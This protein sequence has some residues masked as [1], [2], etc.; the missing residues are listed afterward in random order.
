M[1]STLGKALAGTLFYWLLAALLFALQAVYTFRSMS[2]IRYE[3]LMESVY[4]VYLFQHRIVYDG[5]STNIGWYGLLLCVYNTF[6]FG[7]NTAKFVRLAIQLVSILCL[8]GILRSLMGAARAWLPLAAFCLSPILLYFNMM[9]CTYGLDLQYFPICLFLV[10]KLDL[11]KKWAA[12]V[13]QAVLWGLAM[14]ACM[15][16]PVFVLYVPVLVILYLRQIGKRVTKSG[17]GYVIGNVL[18]SLAAFVAPLLIGFLYVTNRSILIYDPAT[19]RGLFRGGGGIHPG[20]SA[21]VGCLKVV[22]RELFLEGQGYHF[23]L[24]RTEFSGATGIVPVAFVM[25]AGVVLFFKSK[26]LR[27][28]LLLSWL[29]LALNLV[30]PNM[31]VNAPGV[32]RCTG[33]LA[34]IYAIYAVVWYYLTNLETR[35]AVLKWA[36]IL[37]CLILPLHHLLAYPK[38]LSN[39]DKPSLYRVAVWYEDK[40]TPSAS[41]DFW[42]KHTEEGKGLMC[43]DER[44]K[45]EMGRYDEICYALAGYR[46]WNGLEEKPILVYDANSG[47][48][49]P[50]YMN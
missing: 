22:L 5:A 41:L 40:A 30:L 49:I 15:S 35:Y 46:L 16:Y 8:A 43:V 34:A 12:A 42:L 19:T 3:G 33:I 37:I 21:L 28:V 13:L 32:R 36:G 10:M 1:K 38:N 7:L 14:I 48:Y 20:I 4:N 29:L 25:I 24:A 45:P 47:K 17:A 39:L 31:D 11:D 23:E 44:G 6:G 9:Q 2:Q 26:S 27:L 18:L 50:L